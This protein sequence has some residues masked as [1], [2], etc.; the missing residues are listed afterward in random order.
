M[1][2]KPVLPA[3]PVP[4]VLKHTDLR[5][6]AA[7]L[8]RA[9]G[10]VFE[11]ENARTRVRMVVQ[12]V[13]MPPGHPPPDALPPAPPEAAPG[14]VLRSPVPGVLRYRHPRCKAP[15]AATGALLP[16]GAVVALIQSGLAYVPVL[17]PV[18]GQVLEL[19]ARDGDTVEYGTALLRHLPQPLLDAPETPP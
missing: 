16:P 15:L 19:L 17:L 11:F 13:P 12:A 9:N 10:G 7:R 5:D 8:G 6:I 14:E 18:R 1:S 4:L 3:L 2:Q